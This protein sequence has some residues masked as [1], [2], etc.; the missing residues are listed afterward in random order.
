MLLNTLLLLLVSQARSH[1]NPAVF[2]AKTE[3]LKETAGKIGASPSELADY[4]QRLQDLESLAKAGKP[5]LALYRLRDVSI[6]LDSSKY[7]VDKA[8]SSMGRVVFDAEWKSLGRTV[9]QELALFEPAKLKPLPQL[10]RALTQYAASQAHNYWESGRLMGYNASLGDGLAYMGMAPASLEFARVSVASGGSTSTPH[11]SARTTGL[12]HKLDAEILAAHAGATDANRR[13]FIGI[14]QAFKL[15]VDLDKKGWYDGALLA[16]CE[17]ILALSN[18][19]P[20]PTQSEVA[21]KLKAAEEVKSTREDQSL[22][23]LFIQLAETEMA[24]GKANSL[25]HAAAITDRIL[26]LLAAD[27]VPLPVPSLPKAAVRVTL[28]RWP[29]T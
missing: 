17:A 2:S 3:S 7:A 28:V 23:A 13:Q 5:E 15:A 29:Y 1:Q 10:N 4:R 20:A 25:K 27:D 11:Y 6:D 12:L 8:S 18:L 24:A 21:A 14:N 16:S 9:S 19:S 26:P 22:R